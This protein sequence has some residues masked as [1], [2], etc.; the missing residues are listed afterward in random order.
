MAEAISLINPPKIEYV[1]NN[2]GGKDLRCL[3]YQYYIKSLG[4]K[5]AS[6]KCSGK[7][8]YASISLK[9]QTIEG[10]V[11][12]KIIEPFI[13]TYLNLKHIDGC[14]PKNNEDFRVKEFIKTVKD[15]VKSNKLIPPQQLYE[16]ARAELAEQTESSNYIA[17]PDYHNV[18]DRFVR[19][20]GEEN[21][22][23][24]ASLNEVEVNETKTKD[25]L[26]FLI[27]DNKK[28]NR[29]LV[30]IEIE[31]TG[32]RTY[33][34]LQSRRITEEEIPL[35]TVT[36]QPSCLINNLQEQLNKST[37]KQTE[38]QALVHNKIKCIHCDFMFTKRG[39]TKHV[40]ARHPNN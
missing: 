21:I 37:I 23:R 29:T 26:P 9:T 12:P 40:N 2:A 17:M 32:P 5:A 25:G 22:N 39:M 33:H 34:T 15:K 20:R 16:I 8:C 28:K 7:G 1:F 11:K 18:K 24:A 36:Q 27:F 3:D 10:E 4:K 38:T 19:I 13:I 14:T 35:N 31:D 30:R 6:F